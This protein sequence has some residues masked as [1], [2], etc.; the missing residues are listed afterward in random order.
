MILLLFSIITSLVLQYMVVP[1]TYVSQLDYAWKCEDIDE[2]F[3]QSCRADT[4][5]LRVR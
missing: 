2:V 5:V 3:Q 1:H 4:A